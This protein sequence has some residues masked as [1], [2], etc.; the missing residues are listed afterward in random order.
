MAFSL[1]H[2]VINFSP[3][4]S[5]ATWF[6]E[7]SC[8][9]ID[10]TNAIMEDE[11]TSSTTDAAAS[12]EGV[13]REEENET[14]QEKETTS[15]DGVAST[16]NVTT[17]THQDNDTTLGD[18][19]GSSA[20]VRSEEKQDDMEALSGDAT[21]QGSAGPQGSSD[22]VR[23]EQEQ[24]Q[25]NDT[26][27]GDAEGS[28]AGVR[29]EE[30]Q[31]DLEASS[32][33]A[34]Q[35]G[36][37]SPSAGPQGSSDRVRQEQEQKKT[38]KTGKR[39]QGSNQSTGK[40]KQ[41]RRGKKA[42]E[43][44]TE[45]EKADFKKTLKT[46]ING[47]LT[48]FYQELREQAKRSN[49][50]EEAQE[51]DAGGD[52]VQA[53][54]LRHIA[55]WVTTQATSAQETAT[56]LHD[57]QKKVDNHLNGKNFTSEQLEIARAVRASFLAQMNTLV[58]RKPTS[59][60]PI[61]M[62]DII[63]KNLFETGHGW[64]LGRKE[65]IKAVHDDKVESLCGVDSSFVMKAVEL[66]KFC[67][68]AKES[69]DRLYEA[70][71]GTAI[72]IVHFLVREALQD[73]PAITAK[74]RKPPSK[75]VSMLIMGFYDQPLMKNLAN[76]Q[77][78]PIP[79][80]WNQ[81]TND[82]KKSIERIPTVDV[83]RARVNVMM[84][85]YAK[86]TR[87]GQLT[88]RDAIQ[89]AFSDDPA[90]LGNETPNDNTEDN[91]SAGEDEDEDEDEDNFHVPNNQDHGDKKADEAELFDMPI[92]CTVYPV[93]VGA[94]SFGEGTDDGAV[95]YFEEYFKNE[96]KYLCGHDIPKGTPPERQP[97]VTR[98]KF[99][100]VKVE[101]RTAEV[102]KI[103]DALCDKVVQAMFALYFAS[104]LPVCRGDQ[105]KLL[106]VFVTDTKDLEDKF[107]PN[108]KQLLKSLF[109]MSNGPYAR[110]FRTFPAHEFERLLTKAFEGHARLSMKA[111]FGD[112]FDCF[113]N[114]GAVSFSVMAGGKGFGA[115][116]DNNLTNT[117][118][119]DL[120]E[121]DY[122]D[123]TTKAFLP[124][125]EMMPVFTYVMSGPLQ[126]LKD[127]IDNYVVKWYLRDST[128]S[129]AEV[130]TLTN[131]VHAQYVC[132]GPCVHDGG[133]INEALVPNSWRGTM[134]FRPYANPRVRG[135]L[136][137]I[138]KR[139][140]L[141]AQQDSY[142]PCKPLIGDNEKEEIMYGAID[143]LENPHK[144]GRPIKAIA[145]QATLKSQGEKKNKN[146]NNGMRRNNRDLEVLMHPL[147]SDT[148]RNC[149]YSE[150][151]EANSAKLASVVPFMKLQQ[152]VA[153]LYMYFE[154]LKM[155]IEQNILLRVLMK[156]KTGAPTILQPIPTMPMS[157]GG[158]VIPE[159]LQ[160]YPKSAMLQM[161]NLKWRGRMKP[162]LSTAHRL[163]TVVCL[164]TI[165][166][167]DKDSAKKVLTGRKRHLYFYGSGGAPN[168]AGQAGA[169][170]SQGLSPE[171][172]AAA[173]DSH[174]QQVESD[175][176][177]IL[178]R[179]AENRQVF[180]LWI[181][182]ELAGY[183]AG[184][185]IR[186]MKE[187]EVLH[188]GVGY[189]EREETMPP[190]HL[191]QLRSDFPHINGDNELKNHPHLGYR[192]WP[193]KRFLF[194]LLPENLYK[195]LLQLQ[196]EKK[197]Q[198][199]TITDDVLERATFQI[200]QVN[201]R[202]NVSNEIGPGTDRA[203]SIVV[204]HM[205]MHL[206]EHVFHL[207]ATLPYLHE[208][209][210]IDGENVDERLD[211]KTW[212]TYRRLLEEGNPFGRYSPLKK[213]VLTSEFVKLM[214]AM[215]YGAFAR[216]LGLSL[217]EVQMPKGVQK[218]SV[219]LPL[220]DA[221]TIVRK[222]SFPHPIR[223][224]DPPV[225]LSLMMGSAPLDLTHQAPRNLGEDLFGTFFCHVYG[226]ACG[227]GQLFKSLGSDMDCLRIANVKKLTNHMTK[228][229]KKSKG[230]FGRY[231]VKQ[232]EK[233][234]PA[235]LRMSVKAATG[236]LEEFAKKAEGIARD[237]L[238]QGQSNRK[239][240]VVGLAQSMSF[241]VAGTAPC[242]FYFVA[243]H[244]I[245]TLAEM[246]PHNRFG[247]VTLKD[248]YMGPGSRAAVTILGFKSKR[249]SR[250]GQDPWCSLADFLTEE[251]AKLILDRMKDLPAAELL[252]MGVVKDGDDLR[253]KMTGRLVTYLD[254]EHMLCKLYL[255]LK[256]KSPPG[257]SSMEPTW[258]SFHCF[259][260]KYNT[261]ALDPTRL[262]T[263]LTTF[264]ED[265]TRLTTF[266]ELAQESVES[267]E[268]TSFKMPWKFLLKEEWPS[269]KPWENEVPEID[270]RLECDRDTSWVADEEAGDDRDKWDPDAE[271]EES[272]HLYW[273]ENDSAPD[274]VD[275]DEEKQGQ[276]ENDQD[277]E[278]QDDVEMDITN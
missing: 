55:D 119:P 9:S 272:G 102:I 143:Y 199:L 195:S 106:R 207:K 111:K 144:Q 16:T 37:A 26:T 72:M 8:C 252:A 31:D 224:F 220:Q 164:S 216:S 241:L 47:I 54:M 270:A 88:A 24:N 259:P 260:I 60:A 134:T 32:G 251:E 91:V 67:A 15:V 197:L 126:S 218:C 229:V 186:A 63:I 194:K 167:I 65:S 245:A 190:A 237:I 204:R 22:R 85:H 104:Q 239:A 62:G 265:R 29:S 81:K 262:T 68:D 40:K 223:T 206:N 174:P 217:K 70:L 263:R 6:S 148:Y 13:R 56:K 123:P 227:F 97:K 42:A 118:L 120:G 33:D 257:M 125:R 231:V 46:E 273:Y 132:Q 188:V 10:K 169:N 74:L 151:P 171:Y 30:K 4:F 84:H 136:E 127:A 100:D 269:D 182:K 219:P 161:G 139:A 178:A 20:G 221:G 142:D 93:T 18:A 129:L 248:V 170:I 114:Q 23:Q 21:Q 256:K 117:R 112:H 183:L 34:T 235:I 116:S 76:D 17:E 176:N 64:P 90:V 99:H 28:S 86:F 96:K 69:D 124:S 51:L 180:D 243:Q 57:A 153:E 250:R 19:E 49:V 154:M 149:P 266:K 249:P 211:S 271:T 261:E 168:V 78:T 274:L 165:Y 162:I 138:L 200:P 95:R 240:Y 181:T 128:K 173:T 101:G 25:D 44:M 98:K 66:K 175:I 145:G 193:H 43:N 2:F 5:A 232:Y 203:E 242:D 35:Q 109:Q 75:C 198:L 159:P 3:F 115:H 184:D 233:Q 108:T 137:A 213:K 192:R 103:T 27:L 172:E 275:E 267:F 152:P 258:H 38:P 140:E 113:L 228:T 212:C 179:M 201:G 83:L 238:K 158:Q 150:I 246:Y 48:N 189:I 71:L 11:A 236:F 268:G 215:S 234:I 50:E 122:Q 276:N 77:K 45:E 230:C 247:N 59:T 155:M 82:G 187:C 79:D 157:T 135:N 61:D 107:E 53:L 141:M 147:H 58:G 105:N 225:I 202:R 254:I 156:N 131:A 130:K 73:F 244:I 14:V 36:S 277:D 191:G 210:N 264:E 7:S 226:R 209:G 12:S 121:N 253:V 177:N 52:E 80:E 208:V 214:V 133:V 89:W 39:K 146:K 94:T 163:A 185:D 1:F 92:P 110:F 166:R 41:R 196:N 222:F 278:N 255:F 160:I 87:S 205:R